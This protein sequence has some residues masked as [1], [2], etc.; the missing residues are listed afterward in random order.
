M[1]YES[2]TSQESKTVNFKCTRSQALKRI[3]GAESGARFYAH[4]TMSVVIEGDDEH[5]YPTGHRTSVRLTRQQALD[6]CRDYLTDAGEAKGDRI[7]LSTYSTPAR[8]FSR[9]SIAYWIG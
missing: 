7:P 8:E 9:G 2:Q 3:R 5:H 1:A 6:M 4:V